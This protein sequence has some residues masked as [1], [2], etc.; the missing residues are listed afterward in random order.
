MGAKLG[1]GGGEGRFV[2]FGKRR[3]GDGGADATG[4]PVVVHGVWKDCQRRGARGF[5]VVV[6]TAFFDAPHL[7]DATPGPGAKV[8]ACCN[9][10]GGCP[11][12]DV[13]ILAKEFVGF[14]VVHVLHVYFMRPSV[15]AVVL[16]FSNVCLFGL[17]PKLVLSCEAI[18]VVATTLVAAVDALGVF[19]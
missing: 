6:Y 9:I 1:E 10:S 3:G 12:E 15:V 17:V 5:A 4:S 18:S 2:G 16:P 11:F 13:R 19:L 8:L 7:C 14:Y